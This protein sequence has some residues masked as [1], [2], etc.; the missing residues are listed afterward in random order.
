[1]IINKIDLAPHVGAD[2][3]VMDRDAR[4][5]RGER[6]FV[7]TNLREGCGVDQVVDWIRRELLFES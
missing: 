1:L 2:L 3:G 6:P 7:F 5:A 4:R